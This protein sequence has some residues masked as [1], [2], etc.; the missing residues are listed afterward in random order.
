MCPEVMLAPVLNLKIRNEKGT[1]SIQYLLI[2]VIKLKDN[3]MEQKPK[4]F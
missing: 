4:E 2:K 3:Q 1:I